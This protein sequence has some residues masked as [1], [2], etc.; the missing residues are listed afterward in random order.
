VFPDQNVVHVKG[1][2]DRFI[3][4]KQISSLQRT[5]EVSFTVKRGRLFLK[6][7]KLLGG[8]NDKTED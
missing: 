8:E 4:S 2:L 3:G 5:Y 6:D 1:N 7:I